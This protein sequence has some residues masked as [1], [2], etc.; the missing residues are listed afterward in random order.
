M[1]GKWDRR[2]D[3][4][5]RESKAEAATPE[6]RWGNGERGDRVRERRRAM[7]R[8]GVGGWG[9]IGETDGD[10]AQ[11]GGTGEGG[12]WEKEGRQIKGK[13]GG[14]MGREPRTQGKEMGREGG[15]GSG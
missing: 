15:M 3:D 2:R 11:G 8:Q 14:E 12:T 7:K 1:E 6:E 10:G 5:G 9:A 4:R 13:S